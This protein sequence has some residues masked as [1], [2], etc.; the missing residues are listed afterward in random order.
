M[1]RNLFTLVS[2]RFASSDSP[3][4]VVVCANG[5]IAA[6]HPP[7]EFPYE[8]SKPIDLDA[9]KNKDQ[10]SSRLSAAA[11]ASAVPREPVNAELKE[12][13]YTSKHEWYSRYAL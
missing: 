4:K 11:K 8:H 12:I 9:L 3:R 1:L 5:T 2:R 10:Q 7:Q 6:W 13:F